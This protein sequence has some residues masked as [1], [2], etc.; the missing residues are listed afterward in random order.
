MCGIRLHGNENTS[1]GRRDQKVQAEC[2]IRI[3]VTRLFLPY[4]NHTFPRPKWATITPPQLNREENPGIAA[5]AKSS[6]AKPAGK[7]ST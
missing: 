6:P 5:T 1:D 2:Y 7:K 3:A 4:K